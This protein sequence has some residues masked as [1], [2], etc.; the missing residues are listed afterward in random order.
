MCITSFIAFLVPKIFPK[1]VPSFLC[2]KITAEIEKSRNVTSV[3]FALL[4]M[5]VK[6]ANISVKYFA[7]SYRKKYA[8]L[9]GV[10]LR[11]L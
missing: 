9:F 10:L 8:E 7:V 3:V 4:L 11:P 6:N 1:I 5:L 2:L